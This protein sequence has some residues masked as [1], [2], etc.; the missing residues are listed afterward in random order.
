MFGFEPGR[1]QRPADGLLAQLLRR[2]RPGEIAIVVAWLSGRTQQGKIGV[3]YRTLHECAG[4][5]AEKPT[6]EVLDV[7][8]RLI[9]ISQVQGRNSGRQRL[10]FV[11]D[12]LSRATAE[13]QHFLTSLLIG[14]LRQGALEGLMMEAL[15]RATDLPGAD[16]RRVV[17]FAG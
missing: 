17:M 14:E 3:G 11:H 15:A 9:A 13:E 10:E 7:N 16:I 4:P 5:S 6:L 2:L 12:L 8:Q 1:R